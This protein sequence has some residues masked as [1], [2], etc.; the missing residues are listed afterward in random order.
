MALK[1]VVITGC[2]TG[3]GRVTA[4]FL[5]ERGWR[6]LATVRQEAHRAELLAEAAAR[7]QTDR[8]IPLLCDI[9]RPADVDAQSGK[10]EPGEFRRWPAH[11]P[12]APYRACSPTA[13]RRTI[14]T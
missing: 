9:T 6:V 4:A 12:S 3:F 7:G 14:S 2:S 8:L 1:T 11:R 10:Q 13:W 5:A